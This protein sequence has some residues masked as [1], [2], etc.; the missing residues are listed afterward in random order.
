MFTILSYVA[1]AVIAGI[2]SIFVYRNNTK[3]I[4]PY[5][6]QVD[7]LWDRWEIQRQLQELKDKL[8]ALLNK[9]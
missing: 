2:V 3:D 8:D 9:Q 1:T 4:D 7:D 6:D 5:A